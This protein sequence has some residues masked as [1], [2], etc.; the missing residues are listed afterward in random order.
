[1]WGESQDKS[2]QKPP[3]RGTMFSGCSVLPSKTR[4]KTRVRGQNWGIT[5]ENEPEL[6]RCTFIFP[7]GMEADY[8]VGQCRH[9]RAIFWEEP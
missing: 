8:L 4:G 1:M 3:G 7:S 6:A 2:R 9:C 5:V